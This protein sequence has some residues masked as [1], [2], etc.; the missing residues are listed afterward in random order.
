MN[1][2]LTRSK[3]SR[4][5]KLIVLACAIALCIAGAYASLHMAYMA[6]TRSHEQLARQSTQKINE[7]VTLAIGTLHSMVAVHQTS[8]NGFDH[9]QFEMFAENLVN[10][11]F[12]ITAA[13]R[14]DQ[15]IHEDL[16]YYTAEIQSHGL[17]SFAP[18]KLDNNGKIVAS[19]QKSQY[20]SLISFYPQ[21]P[22]TAG[23]IGLDLSEHARSQTAIQE[24]VK[25]YSPYPTTLPQQWL[26]NGQLNIFVPSF[27]GHYIPETAE[28]RQLQTDGGYFI[29]L[30]LK[31][32]TSQSTPVTFPLSVNIGLHSVDKKP[33]VSQPENVAE[34]RLATSIFQSRSIDHKLTIG[35]DSATISY[36]TP[37]GLTR[38]Q[39][40][41]TLG[42]VFAALFIFSI[43][44]AVLFVQ[45]ASRAQI[46]AN[47]KEIIRERERAL[48]TLSSLQDSVITTDSKDNIDYLNP[49]VL[50]I[51]NVKKE[52][53]IG[54][55][56]QDVLNKYF[57]EEQIPAHGTVSDTHIEASA[58]LMRFNGSDTQPK[59]LIFSCHSSA[60]VNSS[61][62]KIG[63]V[64]TMRDMS[65]E[66]ALTTELAHQATHDA[67]TGLPNR[68]QFES[69]LA[70]LLKAENTDEKSNTVGYIDL[71]QFKLINDTVGHAAGDKLLKKLA[72]DLQT[73]APENVKVARLGGD[74]FGFIC[75]TDTE[76]S[77]DC[78]ESIARLFHEFFQS[79]F[80]HANDQAFAIRASIG[81]SNIKPYH[82]NINDVL[83]EVDIACYTAKDQ[84]R[85]GYV[86]YDADD[87]DTK[88]REGEMLYLPL[89]Q[90]ALKENRFLLY[91]QPIVSTKGNN[92]P[93]H[94]YE[95]LLRL[96]DDD[97][98]IITPYKFIVAAERY[99]LITNIDRWV[100]EAAFQQIST[101]KDTELKKTIFS[102]NL[103]GQSA[104]DTSM[105]GFIDE[106]L[107]KHQ[108]DAENICF[109]LTE[110][111]VITNMA[112]AQKLI[113]MVRDR[114]CTIALDDFGAGASSF[115][116]LKN[117][118]VD[119]LKIDGQFV[120]EMTTNKVDF[121]MVRSMN[122]VGEALGIKTI[123]EFV[124]SE[125]IMLALESIN[126]DFAQG[127]Y[128]GKPEP[129]ADLLSKESIQNAA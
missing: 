50:R 75:T 48:I 18:T 67:L 60:I 90:S 58:S 62:I 26:A 56:L 40:L 68:R 57:C 108:I 19:E 81:I 104:V 35:A 27:Y 82:I 13:G 11:Q 73:L 128:I 117:L 31:E 83:S 20:T 70:E 100:I 14:F 101:F 34:E 53:L 37:A 8:P 32:I 80:F 111:A 61:D 78:E 120:K 36:V 46:L 96:I 94:H 77:T 72:N 22:V 25:S 33:L 63:A 29:T 106:M 47:E 23:F 122:N 107:Q 43:L 121:E 116:Y 89:L 6:D 59:N 102:I 125:E 2:K 99:D 98:S 28:D 123:A 41:S 118:E 88:E 109:E 103:S 76:N 87:K 5:L 66:H 16:D 105:P 30:D 85:N 3:F 17:L 74:E 71:D 55:P 124:E 42:R 9:R 129:M 39:I 64:L 127:Y 49:A 51:L 92:E 126:V 84:G 97:G 86:I 1:D 12:A 93:V 115:G 45:R 79:Y 4:R 21:N 44:L 119:Y 54:T 110:T 69:V 15:I 114:G 91:T 65:K 113:K 38:S 10:N 24:S 112:Q 52:D 95:C 7:K